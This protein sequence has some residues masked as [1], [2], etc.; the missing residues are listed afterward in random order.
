[1][2][3]TDVGHPMTEGLTRTFGVRSEQYCM[4]VGPSNPVLA[5]T[6]M[7]GE[8]S[9]CVRGVRMPLVWVRRHG[10][11]R[12]AY[13]AL[14]HDTVDF[15]QEPCLTLAGRCVMWAAGEPA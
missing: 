4:H 2:R 3:L 10:S 15:A 1:M 6:Q 11:G 8:G 13:T 9:E 7:V 12:V 14:D 5:E